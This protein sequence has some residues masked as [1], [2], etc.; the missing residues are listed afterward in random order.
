M[1]IKKQLISFNKGIGE[2]QH[3][4]V[5]FLGLLVDF[6][7]KPFKYTIKRKGTLAVLAN[8]PS[9]KDVLSRINTSDE[10]KGVEFSVMNF[11]AFSPSFKEIKPKFYCLVDPMFCMSTWHDEEV[12]KVFKQLQDDVDWD[13]TLFIPAYYRLSRF[14]K[15]SKLT[16]PRINIIVLNSSRYLGNNSKIFSWLF[17]HGLTIPRSTVA[18]TCIYTAI[19]MGFETIRLYGMEHT[20][21]SSLTVSQDCKL[22]SVEEHFYGKDEKL[23]PLLRNSDG[24]QFKISDFLLEKSYLFFMHDMLSDYAK[25]VKCSII[26]C[27]PTTMIDSYERL[28]KI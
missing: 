24:K 12:K 2:I 1:S 8:G 18:Q 15:F 25:S 26:N 27:T 5:F 16:N 22:C 21:F 7:K 13:M 11:F 23:K 9:L 4:L 28:K 20:F 6:P 17:K 10:F 19:N 3:L 14:K